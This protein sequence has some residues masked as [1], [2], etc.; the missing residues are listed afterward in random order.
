MD[1]DENN[2]TVKDKSK[3]VAD[4]Q[5]KFVSGREDKQSTEISE[6]NVTLAV[7]QSEIRRIQSVNQMIKS[8]QQQRLA[9]KTALDN[10]D[11]KPN[12]KIIFNEDSV[13]NKSG[14]SN[15]KIGC[16]QK[17]IL[18]ES[19]DDID[20]DDFN[21]EVKDYGKHGQQLWEL[22][23]R[24]KNDKRFK[25]DER[26]IEDKNEDF[27]GINNDQ[28]TSRLQEETKK[29]ID[30][31]NQVLGTR[32]K[33]K[34]FSSQENHVTKNGMLRFDPTKDDHLK[35][36]LKNTN[37][38]NGIKLRASEVQKEENVEIQQLPV[39]KDVFYKV[40]Y[41]LKDALQA[42][43][44]FSLLNMFGKTNNVESFK[45]NDEQP[46]TLDKQDT[47]SMETN[48]FRYDS[49]DDEKEVVEDEYSYGKLDSS[50]K[51]RFWHEPFFFKTDDYRLQEGFDFIKRVS[52]EQKTEFV[53]QRKNF[54]NVIKTK[55]R[56]IQRKN[57]LFKNKLGGN[58]R[59]KIL[60]IKK[61]MKR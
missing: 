51:S 16:G 45:E 9:I 8:Y 57:N 26:F 59:K 55:V 35:Y 42:E 25:L 22:Q 56:N 34:D 23:A 41:D 14:S 6:K 43:P 39:S 50:K 10:L 49:S 37:K 19:D 24:Y 33:R 46:V 40:N 4:S 61:A 47:F 11:R 58:K 52:S 18:F 54:K 1:N 12:N 32:V 2:F 53:E 7:N 5:Q 15:N 48:P 38:Q 60:R 21:F 31:L 17:K 29:Q 20:E 36:E 27:E 44:K 28:D 13:T 30:I 3:R